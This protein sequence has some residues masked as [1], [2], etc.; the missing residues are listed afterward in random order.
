MKSSQLTA[1]K[2]NAA[3]APGYYGDGGGLCMQVSKY[4]TR[5][6]VF[7][8]MMNGRTREMGLGSLNTF[9]LKEA[10]ERA[11]ECRQ[12]VAIGTDPIEARQKKRDETR[13]AAAKRITF[14]EAAFGCEKA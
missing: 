4:G 5:N 14:E 9:S 2:V 3:K 12:L 6:W 10:R 8:F 1:R 13:A 11:R 7:R